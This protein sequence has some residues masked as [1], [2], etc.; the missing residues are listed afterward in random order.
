MMRRAW[1]YWQLDPIQW[2][3]WRQPRLW[4]GG[5]FDPHDSQEVT[6]YALMRLRGAARDVFMLSCIEALDYDQ[7]GRHLALTIPEV[8]AHLAA[9]LYQIDT[10]VRFIE[11][12]RPRLDVG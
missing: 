8:E 1:K 6:Y 7:I 5:G 12:T 4:G 11:R 2:W 10:M 9:A 3:R